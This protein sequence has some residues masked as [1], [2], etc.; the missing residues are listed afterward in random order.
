VRLIGLLPD[1][2]QNTKGVARA[3]LPQHPFHTLLKFGFNLGKRL[4]PFKPWQRR[5]NEAVQI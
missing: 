5:L 2:S 3:D 4:R 1:L